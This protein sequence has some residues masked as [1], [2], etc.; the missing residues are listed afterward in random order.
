MTKDWFK[1]DEPI[2]RVVLSAL[3]VVVSTLLAEIAYQSAHASAGVSAFKMVID[4]QL[5]E[6][7][8][9]HGEDAA[10]AAYEQI[11][12]MFAAISSGVGIAD[13]MHDMIVSAHEAANAL[14]EGKGDADWLALTGDQRE[15]IVAGLLTRRHERA[16]LRSRENMGAM[17]KK[18]RGALAFGAVFD[19]LGAGPNATAGAAAGFETGFETGDIADQAILDAFD[20]AVALLAGAEREEEKAA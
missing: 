3:D 13:A 11:Q 10:Q 20:S 12:P 7:K 19:A 15:A 16:Q 9:R 2:Q 14:F 5:A 6:V 18:M 8:T 4:A 1:F 17:A